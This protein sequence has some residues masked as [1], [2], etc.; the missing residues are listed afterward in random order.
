MKIL[1]NSRQIPK[2]KDYTANANYCDYLYAYLQTMSSWDGY[3][4]HPRY[5]YKKAVNFSRIANDLN[6]SRQTISKKFKS[7]LE[8]DVENN[9]LPLIRLSEDGTKYELVSLQGNLAMLVPDAT[10]KVLVSTLKDKAISVYVY[11]L[12]RYLANC[13]NG[14]KF[15]YNELKN[16]IGLTVNSNGNNYIISSIL[17]VLGKI[18]LLKC[19]QKNVVNDQGRVVCQNWITWMTNDIE[20]LPQDFT[21]QDQKVHH[22]GWMLYAKM[23]GKEMTSN[24]A[25]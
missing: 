4:T 3:M 19:E 22:Q 15:S 16:V 10:L 13:E 6:K 17:F 25:C 9:M 18:G 21:D 1:D 11:L 8:G 5:V 14:F 24:Q 7:M 23:T 2:H 20:D 12:N